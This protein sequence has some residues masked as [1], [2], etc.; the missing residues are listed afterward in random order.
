MSRRTVADLSEAALLSLALRDP[1]IVDEAG[2]VGLTP[3]DFG[4][5]RYKALWSGMVR[6]RASGVGPDEATVLERHETDLG[7]GRPFPDLSALVAVVR[8]IQSTP[9]RRPS[10]DAYVAAIVEYRERRELLLAAAEI[11]AL[12]AEGSPTAEIRDVF[13]G[14][15]I[16]VQGRATSAGSGPAADLFV[17]AKERAERVRAGVEVDDQIMTGLPSL[18]RTL[19]YHPGHHALMAGRPSMGKTQ[20]ALGVLKSIAETQGPALFVSVEMGRDSLASRLY[21]SSIAGPGDLH[22]RELEAAERWAR[23]PLLV[24]TE[25]RTLS[26]VVSAIRIARAQHGIIAFAVDYLQRMT[27]PKADSR[28]QAVSHASATLANLAHQ[29]G[30]LGIVLSQLNRGLESRPDKRPMMSDLRESGS[31]EQD[32]DSIVFVYR[33][34]YYNPS[35]REPTRADLIIS[36]QRNGRAGVTVPATFEPGNGWFR[37]YQPEYAEGWGDDD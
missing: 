24:E 8:T 30:M 28:E 17:A 12:H 5:R 20:L 3:E 1:S 37:P 34:A 32:A 27:L 19:R 9:A 23:T 14:A 35:T 6:D 13:E 36:K 25:A 7:I 33:D 22:A 4:D 10:F 16:R 29:G 21:S 26:E 18:D 2:A 15:M 11:Q 31:L